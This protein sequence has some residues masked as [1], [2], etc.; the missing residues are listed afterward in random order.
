M[1]HPLRPVFVWS[2]TF[3]V[4]FTLSLRALY[5]IYMFP[6]NN[7]RLANFNAFAMVLPRFLVYTV[8]DIYILFIY[9]VMMW[10]F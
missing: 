10:I 2:W 8:Y 4:I 1:D 9:L 6:V 7:V 5:M 3:T